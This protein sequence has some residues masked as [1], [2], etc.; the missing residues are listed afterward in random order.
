MSTQ[1]DNS[2]D[3]RRASIVVHV[4]DDNEHGAAVRYAQ[5]ALHYAPKGPA[6]DSIDLSKGLPEGFK[7]ED[8]QPT[9][10]HGRCTFEDLRP[11]YYLVTYLHLP[12]TDGRRVHAKAG[13]STTV[14]LTPHINA[15]VSTQVESEDAE[16]ISRP[17]R[18][19][20]VAMSTLD[21]EKKLRETTLISPPSGALRLQDGWP[22]HPAQFSSFLSHSGHIRRTW[23]FRLPLHKRYL[24]DDF[25]PPPAN[26]H[27]EVV[28]NDDL[29]VAPRL[30][31][32]IT[33]NIGVALTR[34]ET[35]S[36]EDLA[37]WT[38]IRSGTD[39]LSFNNYLHF[40]ELL[41]GDDR[42]S[43]SGRVAAAERRLHQRKRKP[44]QPVSQSRCKTGLKAADP[45][46]VIVDG[47]VRR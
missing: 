16:K 12:M 39:A 7:Y 23:S 40:M 36:T 34:T 6:P 10:E 41:F 3:E 19:G 25:G 31:T 4:N 15:N 38:A 5:I 8:Q 44:R 17:P 43:S 13:E 26:A 18:Q 33:G 46:W 2:G 27:A 37:L 22:D 28:H 42:S 20:D 1:S 14:R 47:S 11:G 9:D 32:P 30:P 45:P 24:T 35:E 29:H 21:V